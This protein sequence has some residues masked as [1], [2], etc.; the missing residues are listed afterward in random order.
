M[1]QAV[2][3]HKRRF[4]YNPNTPTLNFEFNPDKLFIPNIK[5]SQKFEKILR[6]KYSLCIGNN[7]YEVQNPLFCAEN[8][9]ND[10]SEIL[11]KKNFESEVLLNR[12]QKELS[13][14]IFIL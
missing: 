1:K 8:D 14:D 9:A 13:K 6:K 4:E 5:K 12:T 11:G 2:D 10:V 7:K 3:R